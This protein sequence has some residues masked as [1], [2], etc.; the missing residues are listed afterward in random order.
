MSC[1]SRSKN[2]ADVVLVAVGE[3][4]GLDVVEPIANVVEVR[5]DQVDAWLVVLGEE[6]SAVDDQ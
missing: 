3:D 6:H 1:F 2:G 4:D 5:Q